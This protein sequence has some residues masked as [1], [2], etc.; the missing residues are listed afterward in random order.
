MKS[1]NQHI[2]YF[3]LWIM[4][5]S[6]CFGQASADRNYI[7]KTVYLQPFTAPPSSF[8][9][10]Q[11]MTDITYYDGLGRK[12][13]EIAVEAS[14]GA[15]S[16]IVQLIAYDSLGR[17][18]RQYLPYATSSASGGGYKEAAPAAQAAF[19]NNAPSEVVQIPPVGGSTPAFSQRVYEA[20][21]LN[22]VAEQGFP[23]QVWQ[24]APSRSATQGRTQ[25]T[26][27][28]GNNDVAFSSVA[29]TRRV[30]RYEVTL[31]SEGLPSLTLEGSYA[32][33]ELRVT[34]SKSEDWDDAATGFNRRLYTTETYEDKQGQL[35]L[36]RSFN[37]NNGTPEMLSTYYVYDA[38][39]NLSYVLTPG[40]EAD[41]ATLP[42]GTALTSWLADYSYQYR[43]D[44]RNRM[45]EQQ[46]PGQGRRFL[47]YNTLDQL[48]ATQDAIQRSKSPQEW[49]ISKYDGLGRVILT[50][51]YT[52]LGSTPQR[53]AIQAEVD[54]QSS[55]NLWEIR[56]STAQ[57]YSNRAWPTSGLVTTL[58]LQYYD[59]YSAPGLPPAYLPGS[60]VSTMTHGLPT[61]S[62]SLV[63]GSTQMRWEVL[64]YDNKG[65]VIERF[66]QHNKGG[67]VSAGNY[68]RFTQVYTFSGQL[69]SVTRRHYTGT[70]ALTVL[71]EYSYDHRDRLTDTWKTVDGGTRTLVSRQQY[72]PVGQLSG[73]QLHSTSGSSFAQSISYSYNARGWLKRITSPLFKETL[74]YQEP[75]SGVTPEYG[76][77]I[78]RQNWQHGSSTQQRYTYRYDALNRLVHGSMSG[79]K[80]SEALR[81]DRLG[82]ITHLGRSGSSAGGQL[83][84]QL[85]GQPPEQHHRCRPG[86]ASYRGALS[87]ARDHQLQL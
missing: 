63:L 72:N 80:G 39:G 53:A 17:V 81:Y 36:T 15:V 69:Q 23:G 65:Q 76:G 9:V 18:E 35:L 28:A 5:P 6:V 31:D 82:N 44:Q 49:T 75:L 73:K 8:S 13:Q 84:L 64:H 40:A 4:F 71:T 48:V 87:Y 78:S 85:Y 3:I 41:R 16:D 58:T 67:V 47:V 45:I 86:P 10:G 68:D 21:P 61:A 29:T 14:P 51:L 26:A 74:Y 62:R 70:L 34:V 43:Y 19:Y 52:R 57:G 42:T 38:F 55:P 11:S 59:D 2:R 77:N 32:P 25:V 33:G 7:K 83:K 50:G 20:S 60:G 27:Y 24:P 22:R 66:I 37:L 1:I 30:A 54:S 56:S 46:L 12:E 79:G